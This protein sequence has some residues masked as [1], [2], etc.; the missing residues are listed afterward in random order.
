MIKLNSRAFSALALGLGSVTVLLAG[1]S[2]APSADGSVGQT[3]EAICSSLTPAQT[4][5]LKFEDATQWTGNF[6]T[7]ANDTVNKTEGTQSVTLTPT[8]GYAT[9]T[10]AALT[11]IPLTGRNVTVDVRPPNPPGN[12][13]WYGNVTAYLEAPSK[14]LSSF[15]VNLGYQQI[16]VA[17]PGTFQTLHFE[18]PH[19]AYNALTLNG[20]YSDLRIRFAVSLPEGSTYNFDNVTF[21][22]CL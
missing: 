15:S 8:S 13:A 18:I 6:A 14:G 5:I 17:A 10:S 1:C 21:D 22:I 4:K 7:L 20:G 12:P 9:I 11:T 3:Q 2:S 16:T 19:D